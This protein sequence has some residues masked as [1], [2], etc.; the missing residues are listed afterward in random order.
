MQPRVFSS[1]RLAADPA[2]SGERGVRG[3]AVRTETGF[4]LRQTEETYTLDFAG[5]MACLSAGDTGL[6]LQIHVETETYGGPTLSAQA[7]WGALY[8]KRVWR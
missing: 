6:L 3:D 5:A 1:I 4:A 7:A 2:H 8:V